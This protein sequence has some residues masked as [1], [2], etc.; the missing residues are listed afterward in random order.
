MLRLGVVVVL[1]DHERGTKANVNSTY[2]RRAQEAL[3]DGL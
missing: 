3:V 1:I 2:S